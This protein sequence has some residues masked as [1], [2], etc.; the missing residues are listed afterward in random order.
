MLL[1]TSRKTRKDVYSREQTELHETSGKACL[2]FPGFLLGRWL[3]HIPFLPPSPP[4][5][6]SLQ[7]HRGPQVMFPI[8]Q[9]K[10]L[11]LVL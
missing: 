3:P 7:F 11:D 5:P 1:M 4:P 8:Q 10:A 6:T 9:T 2:S